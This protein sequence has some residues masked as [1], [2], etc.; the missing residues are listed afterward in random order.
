MTRNNSLYAVPE[1]P[2]PY[3]NTDAPLYAVPE[4]PIIAKDVAAYAE[5]EE[6]VPT[7]DRI[8]YIKNRVK[9]SKKD[10]VR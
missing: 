6:P 2:A 8:F 4:E 10:R 3:K 7:E 1:E 5:P 9:N